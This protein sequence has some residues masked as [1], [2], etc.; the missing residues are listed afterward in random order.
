MLIA[1]L[2][3]QLE[4]L[5][6]SYLAQPWDN[7]GLQVGD[8]AAPV[9]K[10]LAALELT[11][12]VFAE[13]VETGCETVLTHHPLVFSAV[14]SLVESRPRE[15]LL[16]GLV[17]RQMSVISCHTNLDAAPGGLAEIA[18]EAL[19][20]QGL[21]P[22]EAASAGWFKL[23][24]FIPVA[25]VDQVAGAVFAAGAGGIG[26]YSGCAFAVEGTGWFTPGMGSN[27]TVGRACVPE[28]TPEVRWETVAPKARL[29]AVVSAFVGAHPYE[30][31][32]FDIYPV[33]G[34]LPRVG[35]G[36]V[37]TLPQAATVR[38]LVEMAKSL[39]EC[40][41]VAWSGDGGAAVRRVGVLP[42]SGRGMLGT[43]AGACDVLITGDV[44]YHDA[45]QAAENGLA[46]IDVPHGEME[47]WAFKRWVVD[48]R[49]EL[50]KSG[51][52]VRISEEWQSPWKQAAGGDGKRSSH[53]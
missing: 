43:A 26:E 49:A 14:R 34:T 3:A 15:R 11:D 47:W 51:V 1:D 31:P 17:S 27:P 5:V 39:Y 37:G 32:A 38:E 21:A 23:V 10:I 42:G 19:G 41:G 46:L 33:E 28:R 6:P 29:A 12:A 13:A 52:T 44:G 35:L 7:S 40:S 4:R 16:R 9:R 30:E 45:E 50:G 22:L 20:L 25:A 24:G 18:A 2:L 8:T 53:D 36:R 48:V